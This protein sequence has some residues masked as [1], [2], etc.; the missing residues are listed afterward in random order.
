MAKS[1]CIYL[2]SKIDCTIFDF[3]F[4][5]LERSNESLFQIAQNPQKHQRDG[6]LL[7][8]RSLPTIASDSMSFV[9]SLSSPEKQ[10]PIETSVV[11]LPPKNLTD[12]KTKWSSNSPRRNQKSL[13]F[14]VSQN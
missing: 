4:L 5:Q 3:I 1:K 12:H 7:Q 2:N 8:L 14:S 11:C 13:Q 6:K 9:Y 10:N